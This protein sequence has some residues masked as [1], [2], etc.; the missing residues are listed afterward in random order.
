M[1]SRIGAKFKKE[2]GKKGLGFAFEETDAVIGVK[3]E[4]TTLNKTSVEELLRKE[5]RTILMG[6]DLS[7]NS[8]REG[9]GTKMDLETGKWS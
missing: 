7:L 9:R 4:T 8:P 5:E 6:K 1:A 2:K 3:K